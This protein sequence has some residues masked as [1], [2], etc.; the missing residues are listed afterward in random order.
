[1]LNFDEI[2]K[3]LENFK[4]LNA[5]QE[6]DVPV[7]SDIEKRITHA[8][9]AYVREFAVD[10]LGWLVSVQVHVSKALRIRA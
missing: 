1:M 4:L 5:S 9:L 6:L 3:L 10:S 7:W 8:H 2:L